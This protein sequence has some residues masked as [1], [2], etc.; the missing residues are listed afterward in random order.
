[1]NLLNFQ[2]RTGA[3]VKEPG[4]VYAETQTVE[5]LLGALSLSKR[6]SGRG[7]FRIATAWHRIGADAICKSYLGEG[8][9]WKQKIVN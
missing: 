2:I 9:F 4:A 1:M 6:S 3:L 7:I 8:F 5:P